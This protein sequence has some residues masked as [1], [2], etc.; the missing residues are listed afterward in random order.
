MRT[1]RETYMDLI[2]METI[3]RKDLL[4]KLGARGPWERVEGEGSE[5]KYIAQ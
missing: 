2:Y 1:L 5:E 4:S 3:K